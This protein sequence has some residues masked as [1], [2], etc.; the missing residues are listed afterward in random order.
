MLI[1]SL[2]PFAD[3][4]CR[5][6]A[7]PARVTESWEDFQVGPGS[8][9]SEQTENRKFLLISPTNVFNHCYQYP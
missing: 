6:A 7:Y 2:H 9:N 3:A 4:T 8:S 1:G 5:D